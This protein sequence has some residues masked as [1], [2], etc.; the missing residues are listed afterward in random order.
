MRS[1]GFY[2]L[3]LIR[4]RKFKFSKN[5]DTKHFTRHYAKP[6]LAVGVFV[7]DVICQ[8]NA[9]HRKTPLKYIQS[10]ENKMWTVVSNVLP[11]QS[12]GE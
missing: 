8:Y 9:V 1:G 11:F 2:A 4:S 12:L 3:P 7:R 10:N 5:V 6:M